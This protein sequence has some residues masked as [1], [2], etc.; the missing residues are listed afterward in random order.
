MKYLKSNSRVVLFLLLIV[1]LQSACQNS[2]KLMSGQS[3]PGVSNEDAGPA[4]IIFLIYS[5]ETTND[6]DMFSIHLIEKTISAGKIKE[7]YPV[8]V[9]PSINDLEYTIYDKDDHVIFHNYLPDPLKKTVE[10]AD[11]SGV[12]N[13]N[14]ITLKNAE[15]FLR[16][17]LEPDAGYIVIA[18]YNGPHEENFHLLTT[19]L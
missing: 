14:E 16:F 3:G 5:A 8:P 9:S 17:Q 7:P 6:T 19:K 10:Y 15:F 12:L 11:S 13:Q 18:K 4:Q 2:R 1:V